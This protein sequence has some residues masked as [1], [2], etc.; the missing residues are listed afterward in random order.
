MDKDIGFVN[1][2]PILDGSNYDYWK[3]RM[4][5]FLKALDSKAWRAVNSGCTHPVT[6]DKEGNS[7]LKPEEKWS[8]G[9]EEV[10]LG[11]SKALNALFNGINRNIFR[12]VHHCELAKDVWDILKN[13]HEGTSKVKMSR[14][15]LL[16][17]KFENLRM[18]EDETIHEFHMNI[19]E[20]ANTSGALGE[21]MTD[22]KLVRKILRSLPKRFAMKVT[23]IE[24]ARDINNLKLDELIGS[25]QTFEMGFDDNSE[26]KSKGIALV[27]NTESEAEDGTDENMSETIVMLGKQFKKILKG[28]KQGSGRR[29]KTEDKNNRI[30]C[31]ECEGYG[32]LRAECPTYLKK[33]KGYFVTWSDGDS[34]SDSEK[35]AA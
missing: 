19:L 16:T 4:V 12:L 11:N 10:A 17:T 26:K 29:S 34:D 5:A 27:S 2:P 25:L 6:K 9:E 30:K 1:R 22:E 35:V 7:E 23:A 33:Q 18:K 32:H 31:H 24:E 14:L 20:I 8:K 3:P 13:T 21:K 15:Q 28:M